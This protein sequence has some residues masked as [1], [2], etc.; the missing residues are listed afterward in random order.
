MIDIAVALPNIPW[1]DVPL[2]AIVVP[3]PVPALLRSLRPA[4]Q[5]LDWHI[6]PIVVATFVSLNGFRKSRKRHE[7]QRQR[8]NKSLNGPRSH[9]P[10]FVSRSSC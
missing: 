10:P 1:P 2:P 9:R 7:A 3:E 6:P 4:S 5:L 8:K